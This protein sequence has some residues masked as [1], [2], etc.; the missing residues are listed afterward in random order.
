MKDTIAIWQFRDAMVNDRFGFSYEGATALFDYLTE[1]EDETGSEFD[2]DPIQFSCEWTE[3]ED[4]EELN[5][6]HSEFNYIQHSPNVANTLK[7]YEA[8]TQVIEVP[9]TQKLIIHE[10]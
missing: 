6:E 7:D 5:K 2:F 1:L 3:Y 8:R 4:I 9:N 10:F